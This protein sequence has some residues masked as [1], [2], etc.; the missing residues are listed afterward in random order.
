MKKKN[1]IA[2]IM[3]TIGGLLFALGMCMCLL[4]QWAVFKQGIGV[5][6]VGIIV[7]IAMAITVRKMS[8]KPGNPAECQGRRHNPVWNHCSNRFGGWH[9]HG[10]GL[11]HYALGNR[12]RHCRNSFAAVPDS[13]VQGIKIRK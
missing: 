7:L 10:N 6:A 4:P 12:C 1:F 13:H 9:V 2:L 3:G 11:A 8:G 5:A